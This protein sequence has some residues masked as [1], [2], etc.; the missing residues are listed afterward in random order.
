MESGVL[1]GACGMNLRGRQEER[2]EGRKEGR[3]KGKEEERKEG[4]NALTSL[5]RPLRLL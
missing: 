3:K 2:R 1:D 5:G 4:R